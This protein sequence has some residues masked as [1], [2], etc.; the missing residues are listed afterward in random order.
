MTAPH[1]HRL[2]ST[3]FNELFF[4]AFWRGM[5][6]PAALTAVN[7]AT[8]APVLI[9]SVMQIR[10]PGTWSTPPLWHVEGS[11]VSRYLTSVTIQSAIPVSKSTVLDARS[12]NVNEGQTSTQYCQKHGTNHSLS[13]CHAHCQAR[14]S[15][16]LFACRLPHS[17]RPESQS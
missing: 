17:A 9:C 16:P 15:A 14:N 6:P 12:F 8:I 11:D 10:Y 4:F 3:G 1:T 7:H 5:H 13:H 2:L